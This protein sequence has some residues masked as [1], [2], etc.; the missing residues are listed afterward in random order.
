MN[1]DDIKVCIL[2]VAGTNRDGDVKNVL[3]HLGIRADVCHLNRVAREENLLDYHIV[4]LPGGFSYGDY[5]RSGAIF[6]KELKTKIGDQMEKFVNEGRALLGICNGFQILVESG[7]LPALNGISEYPEAVLANN[8]SARFECRWIAMKSQDSNCRLT[9]SIPKDKIIRAPIAH[10]EGR[11]LVSENYL[12]KLKDNKQ[13]VF[14]YYKTD[15]E[16][17]KNEYPYNPNGAVDDIA[18]IC[19]PEGNVLAFMP[20][21]EDSFFKYQ[22]PDWTANGNSG[23]YGDGFYVFNSLIEYVKGRF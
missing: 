19:N 23:E 6:G 15:G 18:G 14:R 22:Y 2:R 16:L 1:A 3:E 4:V 8:A 9:A 10:G 20:H 11:F 5:I 13:I 7:F 21:P 12:E 17:A